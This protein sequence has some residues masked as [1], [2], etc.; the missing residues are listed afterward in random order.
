MNEPLEE[1]VDVESVDSNS[2]SISRS[3]KED[4]PKKDH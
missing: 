3:T 1:Q 4:L 2:K